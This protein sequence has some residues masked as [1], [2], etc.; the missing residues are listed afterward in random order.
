MT[1]APAPRFT[2]VWPL[3]P[4]RSTRS[5]PAPV[6][7]VVFGA[8]IAGR[9]VR[10][11]VDRDVVRAAAEIELEV[12]DL[13]ERDAAGLVRADRAGAA[14]EQR[15][16]GAADAAGAAHAEAREPE[17]AGSAGAWIVPSSSAGPQSP[18]SKKS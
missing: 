6:L 13:L 15:I 14:A 7:I 1:S 8:R 10:E 4:L 11:R 18:L 12:R 3:M 2:K 9:H 16:L 17:L 5:A